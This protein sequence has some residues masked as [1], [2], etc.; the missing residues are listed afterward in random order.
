MVSIVIVHNVTVNMQIVLSSNWS[1]IW[2][3]TLTDAAFHYVV[4]MLQHSK[5]HPWTKSTENTIVKAPKYNQL[6]HPAGKY[7]KSTNCSTGWHNAVNG[8]ATTECPAEDAARRGRL[9]DDQYGGRK[10]QSLIGTAAIMVDRA[11]TP[12]R[13]GHKAD[14]HLMDINGAFRSIGRCRL[15]HTLRGKGMDRYLLWWMAS[16]LTDQPVEKVIKS[17]GMDKHLVEAGLQQPS[18]MSPILVMIYKSWVIQWVEES[19]SGA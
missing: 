1:S 18:L 13:A 8:G 9:D 7:G 4:H 15:S 10:R 3:F 6:L 16:F 2:T 11:H 5:S 12:R 17:I 14:V 19:D